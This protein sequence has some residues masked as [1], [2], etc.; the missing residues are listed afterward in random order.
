MHG[1]GA[2]PHLIHTHNGVDFSQET[3]TPSFSNSFPHGD[4]ATHK[5]H[6]PSQNPPARH[7]DDFFSNPFGGKEHA[8]ERVEG[9]HVLAPP[10]TVYGRTTFPES[11]DSVRRKGVGF[12]DMPPQPKFT[13]PSGPPYDPKITTFPSIINLDQ[14]K[15]D[16]SK[17]VVDVDVLL[18]LESKI[19]D[20]E[21]RSLPRLESKINDLESRVD[22]CEDRPGFS[23]NSSISDSQD[24][25][26]SVSDLDRRSI[27]EVRD[28]R[29]FNDEIIIIEPEVK[30]E[31]RDAVIVDGPSLT[32]A[33]WK[34]L[35]DMPRI[36]TVNEGMSSRYADDN[37]GNRP[38]LGLTEEFSS[39]GKLWRK[40]LE[41]A[42]PPFYE[43]LREVSGHNISDIAIQ[44]NVFHL[45]EPFMVLFLNRKQLA[46]YVKNTNE[47]TPAKEHAKFILNFL[48]SDFGDVSRMLDNFESMTPPNLVKYCDLWM[49]Y[50]PGTT[51]YSRANGEWEAFVIDSLDGMQIR[52]PSYDNR[53]ALTRLDIRAWSTNFDGEVYGRVW[54]IHC[55]APFHGVRD[56]SSL[57]LVPEKFL[58]DGK[59]IRESLLSRGKKF[60]SLQ[61]QHC[62]ASNIHPSQSTRV[63]VDHLA[64]QRRTGWLISIDGKYG[65]SSAKNRSW[66]EDRYS[67]WDKP[68][69]AFD[70]GPRRHTPQRS[71]VRHFEN[72]YPYRDYRLESIYSPEDTQ[73]EECRSYSS[74]RPSHVVVCEFEK[75]NL[76]RSVTEMD[77]LSLILCPQHVHGF[78]FYDNVW[79]KYINS[80]VPCNF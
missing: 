43:L 35:N 29:H 37:S 45:M 19:R 79:S 39:N 1:Y 4:A 11:N 13:V 17:F 48:K 32:V 57:P 28:P 20:L 71:L 27:R 75:Y 76:V 54:S 9:A 68:V 21:S 30:K 10:A 50:R 52:R 38:L 73:A 64:Y 36:E 42:S 80:S 33:R 53:H 46:D 56:I 18:R 44:D 65:P 24:S 78:S 51:V 2:K 8:S 16:P 6:G 74:D 40:R 5:I 66:T 23:S 49:L 63:M 60:C 58:L 25:E 15:D 61:E 12:F 26:D 55:V 41:I 70:R 69:E 62:E 77:E 3:T 47:F 7:F 59:A 22:E 31:K 67:D 14:I 72:E 34:C